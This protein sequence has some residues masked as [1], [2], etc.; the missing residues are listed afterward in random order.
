MII[1][2]DD[3]RYELTVEA[4]YDTWVARLQGWKPG[5][6]SPTPYLLRTFSTRQD[7]I[8]ALAR[9]WHALFPDADP[10]MWREPVVPPPTP[11]TQ[12]RQTSKTRTP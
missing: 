10:L 7:A 11:Q 3:Q 2:R 4:H 1:F 5:R 9:K 12:R 6:L 8:Y